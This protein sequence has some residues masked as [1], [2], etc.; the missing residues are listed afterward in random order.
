VRADGFRGGRRRFG[1]LRPPAVDP[2]LQIFGGL[3]PPLGLS[4]QMVAV[5]AGLLLVGVILWAESVVT[6]TWQEP[7]SWF[8]AHK[9]QQALERK[10]EKAEATALAQPLISATTTRAAQR[11][12][13]ANLARRLNFR[14]HPG[15]PLG[16]M[17]IP[18]L[19]AR[20]VFVAGTSEKSL[21][22]GP[23]HYRGT[24]LPGQP[25]T[26]GIAG[27]RTTYLA[28]FRHLDRLHKRDQVL[29]RMPYGR[30]RYRVERSIVVSPSNASSLRPAR[31]DRLVLT[32][33]TPLFSAAKRL[34]VIAGLVSSAPTSARLARAG[35]RS[36]GHRHHARNR[37]HHSRG[38]HRHHRR[39]S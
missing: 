25:G 9:D 34:I 27:H 33:C 36:R 17:S 15:D 4:W 8:R 5:G 1:S 3:K 14:T 10:L 29:L 6:I 38:R 37:G 32:T 18:K 21:E 26:V 35:H 24:V 20:F 30:F 28:P 2:F 31:H 22:K 12:R 23:G 11:H 39:S 13:I 19:D 7:I 16:R